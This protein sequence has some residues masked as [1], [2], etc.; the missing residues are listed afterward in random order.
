MTECKAL[1]KKFE[2]GPASS[3]ISLQDGFESVAELQAE[4]A[5]F[6][7][8]AAELNSAENLFCLP[9][10]AF[11]ALDR[12]ERD[13][14]ELQKIYALYADHHAQVQE[15]ASQLWAKVDFQVSKSSCRTSSKILD[16][17]DCQHQLA[18]HHVKPGSQYTV[19]EVRSR[20]CNRLLKNSR[21]D[22]EALRR[23]G[24]LE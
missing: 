21:R 8:R 10:T 4:I 23:K 22:S 13:T 20:K 1:Q 3:D 17:S 15:W 5:E 7:T 19:H 24:A 16:S 11:S 9:I 18:S 14:S 12:L 2:E 6:K